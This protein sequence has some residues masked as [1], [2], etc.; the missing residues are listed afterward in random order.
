MTRPARPPLPRTSQLPPPPGHA[1]ACSSVARGD[2][3]QPCAKSRPRIRAVLV[4]YLEGHSVR[5]IAET[6]GLKL[7]TVYARVRLARERLKMLAP[8]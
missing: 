5:E 1:G 8:A 3:A 2:R 4:P 7:K 6:L